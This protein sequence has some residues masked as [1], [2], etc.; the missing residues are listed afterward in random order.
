MSPSYSGE[1]LISG[2]LGCWGVCLKCLFE[3]SVVVEDTEGDFVCKECFRGLRDPHTVEFPRGV[4]SFPNCDVGET[5]NGDCESVLLVLAPYAVPLILGG[6]EV[7][8]VVPSG[9]ALVEAVVAV[10]QKPV[11]GDPANLEELLAGEVVGLMRSE[12]VALRGG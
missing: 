1:V 8:T 7:H 3:G 6:F 11:V 2:V 9:V 12:H 4:L 10:E 5:L